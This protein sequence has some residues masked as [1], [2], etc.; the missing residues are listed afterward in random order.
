MPDVG[1]GLISSG[2]RRELVN[3]LLAAV[4]TTFLRLEVKRPSA[5]GARLFDTKG[6][7]GSR[8]RWFAWAPRRTS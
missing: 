2:N 6:S 3:G 8:A 5:P 1:T 4:S 7:S